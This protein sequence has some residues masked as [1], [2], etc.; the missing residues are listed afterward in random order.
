MMES[1][2]VL[3]LTEFT[4][5]GWRLRPIVAEHEGSKRPSRPHLEPGLGTLTRLMICLSDLSL[6][7]SLPLSIWLSSGWIGLIFHWQ[8]VTAMACPVK[9]IPDQKRSTLTRSVAV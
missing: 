5:A 1:S 3:N 2:K 4:P 9:G 7:F 8:A 6:W